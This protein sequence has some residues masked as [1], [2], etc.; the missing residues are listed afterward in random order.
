MTINEKLQEKEQN[1]KLV[2]RKFLCVDNNNKTQKNDNSINVKM[3][4]NG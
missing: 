3:N 1:K 2:D 4:K